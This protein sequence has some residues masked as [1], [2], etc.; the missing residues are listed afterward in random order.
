[1]FKEVTS[2]MPPKGVLL[3]GPPN[4]G[5][6]TSLISFVDAHPKY[7]MA[8]IAYPGEQGASSL[9][10]HE[11]ITQWAWTMESGG[12][13]G[14][15]G[16]VKTE[17]F[18]LT[19]E[20]IAG[21]HGEFQLF[22]GDGI[23]KLYATM[24]AAET[25]GASMGDGEFDPRVYGLVSR[26]FLNYL[27]AIQDAKSVVL[28]VFTVWDGRE[29]DDPDAKDKETQKHIFPDLPGMM[30]KAI[31]GEFGVV[32][33][34]TRMGEKYMWQ[35]R[36]SGKVWGCGVKLP[37]AGSLL[38]LYEPQDW[39]VVGRKLGLLGDDNKGGDKIGLTTN[40]NSSGRSVVSSDGSNEIIV[41]KGGA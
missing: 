14:V 35:T 12:G 28:P 26:K 37:Q 8:Y 33:Y 16:K 34:A 18:T 27:H 36:P 40:N 29:K 32:L 3:T 6:T 19:N 9:P 38:N 23:H 13:P 31:M 5:K 17:V 39:G 11:R 2:S 22:A 1:M 15:W 20:I 25:N 30:A 24:L 21:K 41:Q 4:S 7:R 10:Q